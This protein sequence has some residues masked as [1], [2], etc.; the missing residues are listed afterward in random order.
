[1]LA[2]MMMIDDLLF[3][4]DDEQTDVISMSP[5]GLLLAL[6]TE[7]PCCL[8][9]ISFPLFGVWVLFSFSFISLL[10]FIEIE[11]FFSPAG[12]V[13]SSGDEVWRFLLGVWDLGFVSFTTAVHTHLHNPHIAEIQKQRIKTPAG[14]LF[15]YIS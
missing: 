10:T 1:M 7:L 2:S 8:V 15:H 13:F 5:F 9:H 11:G 3:L 12:K 14:R 6:M 4:F